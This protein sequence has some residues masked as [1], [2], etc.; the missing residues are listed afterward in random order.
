MEEI[1]KFN[2]KVIQQLFF[3]YIE[4]CEDRERQDSA[5]AG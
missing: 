5:V 4:S 3:Q 1:L 2:D